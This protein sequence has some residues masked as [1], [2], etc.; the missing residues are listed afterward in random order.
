MTVSGMVPV[1]ARRI[2]I[3]AAATGI[4]AAAVLTPAAVAHA[5]PA[6]A[7]IPLAVGATAGVTTDCLPVGSVECTTPMPTAVVGA[8]ATPGQVIQGIF[9]NQFWW[10]G[11]ANPDK[12]K[13]VVL[14]FYP[15]TLVPGFLQPL[16]SWFEDVNLQV[17]IL[18]ATAQIGPYGTVSLSYSRGC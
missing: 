14:A 6:A 10:F 8:T 4:A 3:A 17:C 18:G 16:F 11:P 1:I 12:P 15:L 9:Q 7:P 5:T 13:T 2:Q